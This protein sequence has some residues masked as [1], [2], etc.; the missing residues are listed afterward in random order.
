MRYAVEEVA[1]SYRFALGSLLCPCEPLKKEIINYHFKTW[2]ISVVH[3]TILM[4]QH[5]TKIAFLLM[6][7]GLSLR[8]IPLREIRNQNPLIDK[9]ND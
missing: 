3:H 5:P 8:K 7:R 1:F 6:K 2:M 4:H 9:V